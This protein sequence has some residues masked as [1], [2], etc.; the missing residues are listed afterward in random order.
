MFSL[1]LKKNI[2]RGL[3]CIP[4]EPSWSE[5]LK[6]QG[7]EGISLFCNFLQLLFWPCLVIV[8]LVQGLDKK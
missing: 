7:L 8:K 5:K 2:A 1:Y 3:M 6:L 4:G